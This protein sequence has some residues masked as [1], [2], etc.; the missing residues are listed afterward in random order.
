METWP[1]RMSLAERAV[2]GNRPAGTTP[3]LFAVF[4]LLV[5]LVAARATARRGGA[6]L[7]FLTFVVLR[8]LVPPFLG[9][10]GRD[11][12]PRFSPWILV[13]VLLALA[14]DLWARPRTAGKPV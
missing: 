4:T 5:S 8:L 7:A 9:A 3:V 13:L 6:T 14:I 11:V 10:V 1:A 2:T 12:T